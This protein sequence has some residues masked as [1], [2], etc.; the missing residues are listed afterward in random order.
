MSDLN[1]AHPCGDELHYDLPSDG[2]I[3]CSTCRGYRTIQAL[4][5]QEIRDDEAISIAAHI[6]AVGDSFDRLGQPFAAE[7]RCCHSIAYAIGELKVHRSTLRTRAE[8][9]EAITK[10]VQRSALVSRRPGESDED[11]RKRIKP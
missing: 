10:M 5:E 1:R 4:S 7:A 9:I 2:R 3:Y 6:L 11:F 8:V